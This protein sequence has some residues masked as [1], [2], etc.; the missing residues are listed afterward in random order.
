[1]NCSPARGVLLL[2]LSPP[3][4]HYAASLSAFIL[5]SETQLLCSLSVPES[6]AILDGDWMLLC[7]ISPTLLVVFHLFP[8]LPSSFMASA[9]GLCSHSLISVTPSVLYINILS[10]ASHCSLV[11]YAVYP[12]L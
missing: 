11:F 9:T 4:I 8:A 6:T 1:M 10:I 5:H 2:V 12:S 7:H 3:L